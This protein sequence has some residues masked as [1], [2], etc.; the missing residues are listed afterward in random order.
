MCDLL[1]C[2]DWWTSHR[3]VIQ[4]Y[5]QDYIIPS[6]I[7]QSL[8]RL[9]WLN[10]SWIYGYLLWTFHEFLELFEHSWISTLNISWIFITNSSWIS[11]IIWTFYGY[12]QWTF[13][14]TF[15]S[16]VWTVIFV[17][18]LIRHFPSKLWNSGPLTF[19]SYNSLIVNCAM[20]RHLTTVV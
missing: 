12:L 14:G 10:I 16:I 8:C 5:T 13:H 3:A 17:I 19:I 15:D 2:Q 9:G 11:G 4:I 1:L 7:I 20:S 18:E 6:K